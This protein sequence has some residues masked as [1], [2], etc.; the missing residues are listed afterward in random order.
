[1]THEFIDY[2]ECP[3]VYNKNNWWKNNICPIPVFLAGGISNCRNWQEE[4]VP[5][6]KA[7]MS[8]SKPDT[9]NGFKLVL[10]NPRRADF[11]ITDPNMSAE[12]IEW[13]H[14]HLKRSS[15][16]LFWFPPETLC[17]ITLYELGVAA[18]NG[19]KIF[20]GCDPAYQR[21]FDVIKQLSLI[22][23]E[24]EVVFTLDDL[25]EQVVKHVEDI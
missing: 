24:V 18:A 25:V 8:A 3:T 6:F 12:Q 16:T 17:P 15:V 14:D 22:R 23:P 7:V 10:I 21:K 9:L 11:D 1:M 2:V 5:L 13:E 4:M 20:V 19:R